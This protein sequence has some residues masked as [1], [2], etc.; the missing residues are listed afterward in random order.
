MMPGCVHSAL[1][2]CDLAFAPWDTTRRPTRQSTSSLQTFLLALT[3]I[4]NRL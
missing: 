3:V 2:D 4:K 1:L